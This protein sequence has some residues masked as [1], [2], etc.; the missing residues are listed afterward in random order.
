VYVNK[1]RRSQVH[2]TYYKSGSGE[3]TYSARCGNNSGTFR[4]VKSLKAW[5]KRI[6]KQK[7]QKVTFENVG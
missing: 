7:G 6:A 4:T 2:C 5:A 1:L 3:G